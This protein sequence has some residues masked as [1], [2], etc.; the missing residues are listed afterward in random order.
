M[1]YFPS[2]TYFNFTKN[3]IVPLSTIQLENESKMSKDFK[4]FLYFHYINYLMNSQT[5]APTPK[6]ST[7]TGGLNFID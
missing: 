5:D 2:G 7:T 4:Y 1:K 6:G 3:I